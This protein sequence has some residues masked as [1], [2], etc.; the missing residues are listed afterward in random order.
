MP[1]SVA[2]GLLREAFG[3]PPAPSSLPSSPIRPPSPSHRAAHNQRY[4]SPLKSDVR[5]H[6]ARHSSVDH[7]AASAGMSRSTVYSLVLSSPPDL[8]AE[9]R[10][11][12]T[13]GQPLHQH[14]HRLASHDWQR[15]R[16]GGRKRKLTAKQELELREF[17][18]FLRVRYL[19][20]LSSWLVCI[21][22]ASLTNSNVDEVGVTLDTLHAVFEKRGMLVSN[23]WM[24]DFLSRVHITRHI[25]H[26]LK[27]VPQG[28]TTIGDL[29]QSTQQRARTFWKQALYTRIE[30][31][32]PQHLL[33]N[34]DEISLPFD[35]GEN[36]VSSYAAVTDD[37]CVC[38]DAVFVA[39]S[40]VV[41]LG[42][43]AVL[44][45]YD[46]AGASHVKTLSHGVDKQACSVLLGVMG[47]GEKLP[48]L[49]VFK[50]VA[51]AKSKLLVP[52]DKQLTH[53]IHVTFT[54]SHFLNE[55]RYLHYIKN[56]MCPALHQQHL[57]YTASSSGSITTTT[58]TS[59]SS[60]SSASAVQVSADRPPAILFHDAVPFHL[61]SGVQ[62]RAAQH[63]IQLVTVP[64]TDLLQCLDLTV[65]HPFK[66]EVR[67]LQG[68]RYLEL[69]QQNPD[70]VV[71]LTAGEWRELVVQW[72]QRV[73]WGGGGEEG[74]STASIVRGMVM[75]GTAARLD[76]SDDARVHV[77][78]AQ[79]TVSYNTEELLASIA[80]DL[81]N[82][83]P[84]CL[85]VDAT[86]CHDHTT[87]DEREL[88][89]PAISNAPS[90]SSSADSDTKTRGRSRGERTAKAK[91]EAEDET[92]AVA[93]SD[94][95]NTELAIALSLSEQQAAAVAPRHS[96][97]T[98]F[99]AAA[100]PAASDSDHDSDDRKGAPASARRRTHK[101]S[102]K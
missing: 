99:R 35:M 41:V 18:L 17:I 20:K 62:Q 74:V 57:R 102:R 65:N 46:S 60:S 69:L 80:A 63:A 47:T 81:P 19:G 90:A 91:A 72:V 75:S 66:L 101:R 84:L 21:T 83:P 24:Q 95:Y 29:Q 16:G 38:T 48:P 92:L 45:T 77:K 70:A 12:S 93:P 85:T 40:F 50:A 86:D 56:I 32:T 78:T 88:E 11:T 73:W 79:V 82:S 94:A 13:L 2:V 61:T 3:E 5:E 64:M 26:S 6:F 23:S 71:R 52:I 37:C 22:Q 87:F 8:H 10:S 33:V 14:P 44:Q 100:P 51:G 25:T 39:V 67:R 15:K 53:P 9:L 28:V 43:A 34:V 4:S 27:K 36:Y 76:G 49:V 89:R 55:E 97:G 96:Y 98:R 68:N 54:S 7:V 59:C 30:L 58:T 31:R 1:K 42:V